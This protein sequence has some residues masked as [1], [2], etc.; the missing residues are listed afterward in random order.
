M[1][2]KPLTPDEARKALVLPDDVIIVVNEFLAQRYRGGTC[3]IKRE[4]VMSALNTR[5]GLTRTEIFERH[6]LDFEPLFEDYGWDIQYDAPAYNETYEAF[7]RCSR[8]TK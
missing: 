4:E 3:I 8:S 7:W 6:Y 5:M 1:S 2:V